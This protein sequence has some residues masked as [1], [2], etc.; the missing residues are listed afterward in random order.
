MSANQ[1]TLRANQQ[2]CLMSLVDAAQ[3]G[4]HRATL[5]VLRDRLA[6]DLDVAVEPRDVAVLALRL[7]DVLAQIEAIPMREQVSAADEIAERRAA[8][9]GAGAKN[10]A[11]APRSG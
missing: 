2:R 1:Q 7:T 11:R 3:T 8:R 10:P 9:R 5:V 6:Q 4:D